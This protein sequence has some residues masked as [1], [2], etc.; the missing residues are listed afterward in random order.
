MNYETR[1]GFRVCAE[2]NDLAP[3][4]RLLSFLFNMSH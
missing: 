1:I 2:L 3:Y 4:L